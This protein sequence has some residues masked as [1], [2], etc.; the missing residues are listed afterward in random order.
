MSDNA[1][2]TVAICTFDRYDLLNRTVSTLL[3]RDRID[4]HQAELLIVDNTP[5]ARRRPIALPEGRGS[6]VTFCDET[7]LSH[8]R[9]L[10]IDEANGEIIAFLDDDALVCSGWTTQLLNAFDA[11]PD[12]LIVG[13]R[14][15]PLY[16][17]ADRLPEWYDDRLASHLSCIDWS[18]TGRFLNEN[19]WVVGANLAIRKDVFRQ[20][21][22]FDPSLGRRG[23]ASLLSNEETALLDRVGRHRTFYCPEA[24]VEHII[25]ADR[26]TPEHFRRRVFWQAI[27]DVVSG[28]CWMTLDLAYERYKTRMVL[29]P[30]Q[31]RNIKALSYL[32]R[33]SAE[34]VVQLESIYAMA[35]IAS[36]GFKQGEDA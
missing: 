29:A 25:A 22:R 11:H 1:R 4:G 17:N 32:P 27:S 13:G 8:A 19:E 2:L 35:M 3:E 6:R 20:Y 12:A 9:N 26:L 18:D 7:G 30:P 24:C 33:T 5:L 16:E 36:A 14:V 23:T 31:Y 10:A 15:V 21:G 34:F 28:S